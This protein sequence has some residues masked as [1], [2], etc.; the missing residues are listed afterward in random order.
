MNCMDFCH[1]LSLGDSNCDPTLGSGAGTMGGECVGDVCKVVKNKVLE[2]ETLRVCGGEMSVG[3]TFF[4]G[5]F[6]L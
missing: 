4:L 6:R 2:T 5:L 3:I 1:L